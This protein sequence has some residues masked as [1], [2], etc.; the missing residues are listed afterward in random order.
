MLVYFACPTGCRWVVAGL[1]LDCR[2]IV[3]TAESLLLFS[4][5]EPQ[6]FFFLRPLLLLHVLII[7]AGA[8]D[9]GQPLTML[10]EKAS[11]YPHAV[12]ETPS[13]QRKGYKNSSRMK[14]SGCCQ[15]SLLI[16]SARPEKHE[17]EK[18]AGRK[19]HMSVMIHWFV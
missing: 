3:A 16:L 18:K 9:T 17:K 8:R 7:G 13:R 1:S 4:N 5:Q 15:S 6:P 12:I 10:S 14:R 2:W 19:P 11:K